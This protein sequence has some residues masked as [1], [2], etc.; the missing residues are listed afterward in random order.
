M[1]RLKEEFSAK[2]WK[3]CCGKGCK[4]CE[5]AQTYIGEY[6]RSEGLEKLNADRDAVKKGAKKG[7]KTRGSKKKAKK[8]AKA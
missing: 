1:T 4:K 5:I 8:K 6:G 3:G 7:G 2:Q